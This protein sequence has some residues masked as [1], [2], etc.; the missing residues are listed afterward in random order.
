ML[1]TVNSP[2]LPR[3]QSQSLWFS[4]TSFTAA[5]F[6]TQHKTWSPCESDCLPLPLP[7]PS[8]TPLK[9]SATYAGWHSNLYMTF[10]FAK[11]YV[12]EQ[13][14]WHERNGTV[15]FRH[16]ASLYRPAVSVHLVY[17]TYAGT[18][19]RRITVRLLIVGLQPFS[20]SGFQLFGF[21]IF[22]YLLSLLSQNEN[23]ST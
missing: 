1:F 2:S 13:W 10:G 6:Q 14:K 3:L 5:P 4:D 8:L 23:I 9:G 7:S 20:F 21:H 17:D 11:R 22:N 19:P 15:V 12:C 18:Q 16:R